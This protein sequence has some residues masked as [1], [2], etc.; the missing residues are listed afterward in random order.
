MNSALGLDVRLAKTGVK[1]LHTAATSL[2]IG[3]YFE[4]NGHG[5]I[6]VSSKFRTAIVQALAQA[7]E[8][9]ES[10]KVAA[11]KSLQAV[12]QVRFLGTSGCIMCLQPLCHISPVG[13]LLSD[14]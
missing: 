1:H 4:A 11:L 6:F 14:R 12:D 10:S 8:M 13:S 3:L 9:E 2:D 7:Q 5:S